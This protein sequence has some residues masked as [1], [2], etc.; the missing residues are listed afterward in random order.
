MVINDDKKC[1]NTEN[2]LSTPINGEK[3]AS[4]TDDS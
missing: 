4:K 2:V 1:Q 3:N